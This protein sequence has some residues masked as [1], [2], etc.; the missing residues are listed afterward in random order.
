MQEIQTAGITPTRVRIV[1]RGA[2]QGVGFRPF[3]YNLA[4]G[5]KLGGEVRNTGEGVRVEIEGDAGA[6]EEFQ[7]RLTRELPPLAFIS[8]LHSEIVSP[9]GGG[10][11]EFTIQESLG[12]G[13]HAWILPDIATCAEC[14]QEIFD[15]HS[16]RFRYPFTNCTHCGPRHSIIEGLPYDRA[17]TTMKEFVMCSECCAEYADPANRRF[18]AQP[19]ACAR[20]GPQLELWSS[21]GIVLAQRDLALSEAAAA[22]CSGAVLALKGIGGF[23]LMAD[24]RNADAVEKLRER[25]CRDA[26]PF[27]MMFPSLSSVW[28]EAEVSKSEE[29][30]LCSPEAPIVILRRKQDNTEVDDSV[31]PGNPFLGVMLPYSPLHHLLMRELGFPVVATSANLSNE[32]ICIDEREALTCLNGVADVFLTHNRPIARHSDDSVVRVLDGKA[33]ILRR[34]RGYAPLPVAVADE[35]P[36]ILAVG[37][38]LKNTIAVVAGNHIFSSQHNGDLDSPGA[39]SSFRKT[40]SDFE[41]LYDIKFEA[42]ACD[43]HPD[44]ASTQFASSLGLPLIGVQHH[45]AH[46]LSCMT[47]NEIGA[48]VLGVCW[49]GTGFGLDGTIWGGEFLTVN[50]TDFQRVA[51]LRTFALPG[52]EAAIEEPRRAALGLL[53]EIFGARVVEF[54]LPPLHMCSPRERSLF[55]KMLIS[56]VNSPRTSSAG[57]L[58]DA[59]ASLLGVRHFNQYEGQAANE[60]EFLA[61]DFESPLCFDFSLAYDPKTDTTVIDWEPMIRAVAGRIA[62]KYSIAETATAVHNTLAEMI[63][64]VSRKAGIERVVLSGGCFQNRYLTERT[65][66]ALRKEGFQPFIHRRLPANDGGIAVGQAAAAIRKLRSQRHVSGCSG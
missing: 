32:P 47:E 62:Q 43:L 52:G 28:K 27:A 45:Y 14:I 57:R 19:I 18:H 22:L 46:V 59:I 54:D 17:R 3:V 48:P 6:I 42:V 8:H 21:R 4:I 34:S 11:R 37:A 25:K 49:D 53:F 63:V 30:L 36:A 33:A 26:K 9:C 55:M 61:G 60:L 51:H 41:R 31:A 65:L 2:V 10:E 29:A 24:A 1:V 44:Y 13:T 66:S 38:H 50:E 39:L 5:L 7:R 23:Q 56:N 64:A 20:C 15:E 40:I 16:R 58:F 35:S 12:G